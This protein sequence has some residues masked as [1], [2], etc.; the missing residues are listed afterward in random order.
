MSQVTIYSTDSCS[1]CA[2][3]KALLAARRVEFTEV[4]L[5]KD[6]EGRMAL[7]SK[8]GMMT[9]PQVMVDGELI[10][11]FNEVLA[12]AQNGQLEELLSGGDRQRQPAA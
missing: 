5:S 3:A 4:N 10:G 7:A 9:F 8:T 11:G 2:R 6:P 1:H 12:A